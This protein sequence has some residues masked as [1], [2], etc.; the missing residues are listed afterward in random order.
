MR[1]FVKVLLI[2]IVFASVS[3]GGLMVS[4]N[5]VIFDEKK[6]SDNKDNTFVVFDKLFITSYGEDIKTASNRCSKIA[7]LNCVFVYVNHENDISGSM[8]LNNLVNLTHE[9]VKNVSIPSAILTDR[10]LTIIRAFEGNEIVKYIN[11][12]LDFYSKSIDK[13]TFD[14]KIYEIDSEAEY[15]KIAPTINLVL[16][17]YKKGEKE[18][19]ASLISKIDHAK[20][21]DNTRI[22]LAKAHM[23]IED[24][25][26]AV[27]VL[28]NIKNPEAYYLK[29][30]SFYMLKNY[31]DARRELTNAMEK[32]FNNEE[33]LLYLKKIDE[34]DVEQKNIK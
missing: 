18:K 26:G 23:R 32:G 5:R 12:I 20:L 33:V 22:S 25:A 2:L 8:K 7:T 27:S 17:L 30:V 15:R 6:F 13:D 14:K 16:M 10:E 24:Y 4:E 9:Q 21:N 19:A 3:Y 34:A 28:N 1:F 29:G 31:S 11:V